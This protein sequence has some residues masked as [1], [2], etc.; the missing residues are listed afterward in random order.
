MRSSEI[1]YRRAQKDLSVQREKQLSDIEVNNFKRM[2]N[3][4]GTDVIKKIAAA[5][6]EGEVRSYL[7]LYSEPLKASSR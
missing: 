4:L 7:I 1:S 5:G 2:V 6:P 3:S